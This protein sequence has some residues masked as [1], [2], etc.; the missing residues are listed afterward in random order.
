MP[1]EPVKAAR[2]IRGTTTVPNLHEPL[3]SVTARA[4]LHKP[5]TQDGIIAA[6][7]DMLRNGLTDY[8]VARVLRLDV[9]HVRRLIGA[10][11]QACE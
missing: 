5:K 11:C 9:Q 8:D 10:G 4:E 6:A 2:G 1:R 3:T 7:R